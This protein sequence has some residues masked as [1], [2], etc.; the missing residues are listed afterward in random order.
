MAARPNIQLF[1]AWFCPYAQRAWIALN[2]CNVDFELIEGLVLD[3]KNVAEARGYNKDARLLEANPHGL[4]PTI[5]QPGSPP[6]FD[7]LVTVE[8]ADDL[9]AASGAPRIMPTSPAQRALARMRA[10]WIN[11]SIA[12]P[13]YTVLVRKEQHERKEAFDKLRAN[14][15]QFANEIEGPLY[16]GNQISSVDIAAFP[17]IYRILHCKV[18]ENFRGWGI[19]LEPA[20][21]AKLDTWQRSM[22]NIPSVQKTLPDTQQLVASYT[23]YADGTALSKVAEAVRQGSSAHDEKGFPTPKTASVSRL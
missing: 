21:S 3:N 20:V 15:T 2:H 1:S 18:L 5:V 16:F 23:R 6:I 22:M 8:Y 7:S 17:W 12:S 10:D 13:F 4:V 14:I 19:D 9:A 11:R